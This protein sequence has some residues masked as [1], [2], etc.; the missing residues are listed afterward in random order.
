MNYYHPPWHLLHLPFDTFQPP[1]TTTAYP[2]L[3]QE[4]L[5]S[6]PLTPQELAGRRSTE[7][8][9]NGFQKKG[10]KLLDLHCIY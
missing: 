5:Q 3:N 10:L 6:D 4:S 2:G 1:P 9:N 8:E 7:A